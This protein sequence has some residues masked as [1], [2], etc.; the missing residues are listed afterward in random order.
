M[1][2]KPKPKDPNQ[3]AFSF[4]EGQA[5]GLPPSYLQERDLLLE[6]VRHTFWFL[7][8]DG[9]FLPSREFFEQK[10]KKLRQDILE[11]DR[12]MGVK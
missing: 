3:Q 10:L 8:G 6:E 5:T 7:K 12:R 9:P 11:L 1:P 4:D 2:S